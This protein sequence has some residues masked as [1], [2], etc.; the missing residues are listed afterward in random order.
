MS[1]YYLG[2]PNCFIMSGSASIVII[3]KAGFCHKT[4][5]T[6]RFDLTDS[7]LTNRDIFLFFLFSELHLL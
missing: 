4:M 7:D 5:T 2:S 6:V 1:I 3:V